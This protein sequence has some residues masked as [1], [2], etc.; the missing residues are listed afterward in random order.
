[1]FQFLKS[2]STQSYTW[3]CILTLERE[4]DNA[5]R[6][7]YSNLYIAPRILLVILVGTKFRAQTDRE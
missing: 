3:L 5:Q 4:R 1:M 6:D 2:I 7:R